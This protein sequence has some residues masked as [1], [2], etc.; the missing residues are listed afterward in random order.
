[1]LDVFSILAALN[2]HRLII[3]ACTVLGTLAAVALAMQGVP[4]YTATAQV[5]VERTNNQVIN[6]NA[7]AEEAP[8]DDESIETEIRVLNSRGLIEQIVVDLDLAFEPG[9]RAQGE[10][11]E[12]ASSFGVKNLIREAVAWLPGGEDGASG[13]GMEAA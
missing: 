13:N 9:F 2:R 5:L 7:D 1:M 6:L 11:A 10:Q 3:L 4:K 8:V 12:T